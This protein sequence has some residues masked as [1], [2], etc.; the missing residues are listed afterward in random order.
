VRRRPGRLDRPGQP[1]DDNSFFADFDGLEKG[2]ADYLI[3]ELASKANVRV[4]EREAKK[5][6]TP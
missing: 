6:P 2:I 3:T 4:L 1:D 5:T